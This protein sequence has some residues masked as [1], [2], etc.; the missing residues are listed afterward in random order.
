MSGHPSARRHSRDY[1]HDNAKF[2]GHN[3]LPVSSD[4]HHSVPPGD[5]VFTATAAHGSAPEAIDTLMYHMDDNF[6]E[7]AP[8][9]QA[10]KL[11][12]SNHS[13]IR[14]HIPLEQSFTTLQTH[15][16]F[17]PGMAIASGSMNIPTQSTSTAPAG[18]PLSPSPR[19]PQQGT[20]QCVAHLFIPQSHRP[21]FVAALAAP[22]DL[23]LKIKKSVRF[24]REPSSTSKRRGA[25]S[26]VAFSSIKSSS[27]SKSVPGSSVKSASPRFAHGGV[28]IF[29][30]SS[31]SNSSS[32]SLKASGAS[33]VEKDPEE[34][35]AE[36]MELKQMKIRQE[37][38]FHLKDQIIH[39]S[40]NLED[41]ESILDEVRVERKS[42]QSELARYIAMVKQIQRDVE[43][44]TQAEVELSK[45]REQLSQQVS[46]LKDS[47]YKILKEEVDQLRFKK[48]LRPLP[49][50]EQ[51]Q[52]DVM[53]RYLEQRRGQWRQDGLLQ[54]YAGCTA[55]SIHHSGGSSSTAASSSSAGATSTGRSSNL[56][57][58]SG[59]GSNSGPGPVSR[60]SPRATTSSSIS[61][62]S[63][64]RNHSARSEKN[65]QQS[66]PRQN[67]NTSSSSASRSSKPQTTRSSTVR[68][69]VATS[70]SSG[71]QS[72]RSSP[73]SSRS[74][75]QS[76]S[77]RSSSSS[78]AQ[79]SKKRSR[80]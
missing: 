43:L 34:K 66:D 8:D 54:E 42:L 53:G 35:V 61:L 33:I 65:V 76:P 58:G 71:R 7:D 17:A 27:L 26:P 80:Y 32:S 6:W 19:M 44:A 68:P 31:N 63:R 21:Q 51:E 38:L 74:R 79:R 39:L 69:S 62:T 57:S 18:S 14:N 3:I 49:S 41:K 72:Q 29:G 45:E 2:E 11:D 1:I 64:T 13:Q 30:N 36:L 9:M 59:S 55:N 22:P 70:R 4:H 40:Q 67:R 37:D 73:S 16:D 60:S 46:Q 12:T 48:G 78:T 75:S 50:L 52:A 47:D 20:A 15:D 23:A 5:S 24:R 10:Q 77:V 25:E 28:G 56:P